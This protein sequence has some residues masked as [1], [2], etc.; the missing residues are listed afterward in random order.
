MNRRTVLAAA[1]V[2]TAGCVGETPDDTPEETTDVGPLTFGDSYTTDDQLVVTAERLE[3]QQTFTYTD[4]AG[5]EREKPST[6]DSKY[7]FLYLAVENDGESMEYT[8]WGGDFVLETATETYQERRIDKS[9][10]EY[11]MAEIAPGASRSG[12]VSYLVHDDVEVA[13]VTVAWYGE[14]GGELSAKWDASV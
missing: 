7:A 14:S 2:A 3:F 4:Y 12:W 11:S 1:A 9:Q 8:P 10:G 6:D 13:D 5:R